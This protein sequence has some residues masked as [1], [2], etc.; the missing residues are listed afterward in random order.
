MLVIGEKLN[1]TRKK[2][3]GII[4]KRDKE[5]VQDLA[6]KQVESGAEILDVNSSNAVGDKIDNIKW[7]VKTTQEVVNVPLC[8]DSPDADEIEKGLEV[9]NWDKG[10]AIINSITG[11]KEKIDRLLPVIKKYKCGVIALAM[12]EKG[13]SDNSEIRFKIAEKLID[14]LTGAG[15]SFKDIFIDPLVVPIGT[16]DKNGLITLETIRKIRNVYP[17]VKIIAGV[18]NISFGLLERKMINQVFMALSMACGLDAAI[19]D[20]TDKKMMAIIK[21]ATTLLGEDSFCMNYIKACRNGK[22]Y[23]S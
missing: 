12:D 14:I 8:I 13:I 5:A 9:H 3:R 20:P 16:N 2:V 1:S 21:V 22:L 18:S 4:E 10:K 17:E 6:R 11:E 19:I 15:L 23:F 7:L